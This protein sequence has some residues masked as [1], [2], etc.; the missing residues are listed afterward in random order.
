MSGD[1]ETELKQN[2]QFEIGWT[3]DPQSSSL[4]TKAKLPNKS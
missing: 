4:L 1:L 2:L 3:M